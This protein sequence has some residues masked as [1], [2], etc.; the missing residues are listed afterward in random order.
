MSGPH[1][2]SIHLSPQF[3]CCPCITEGFPGGIS[4]KEPACQ[5]RR[6]NRCRCHPWVGKIP[7]RRDGNPLQ[8]SS[9]ENPM[10]KGAWRATVHKVAKSWTRLKR[11]STQACSTLLNIKRCSRSDTNWHNGLK[12]CHKVKKKLV[13][14]R[15]VNKWLTCSIRIS[16]GTLWIEIF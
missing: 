6:H 10:D 15:Q 11:L 12:K 1:L 3:C 14:S 4:G 2:A 9:L 13:T 5:Y 8:Y 16:S 7:W